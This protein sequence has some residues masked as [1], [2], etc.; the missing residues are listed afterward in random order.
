MCIRDSV[1][2]YPTMNLNPWELPHRGAMARQQPKENP[3]ISKAAGYGEDTAHF[4]VK[5][6]DQPYVQEAP[7]DWIRGFQVG[8]R[9]SPF[10]FNCVEKHLRDSLRAKYT[11]RHVV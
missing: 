4:F 11:D 6:R 1:K 8:G 2:D 7:F 9:Y 5:D 3:L 10:D